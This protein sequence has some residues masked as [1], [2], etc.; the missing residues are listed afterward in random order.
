MVALFLIGHANRTHG[1]YPSWALWTIYVVSGITLVFT[2]VVIPV[3]NRRRTRF[4]LR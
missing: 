3:L 1:K 2:L 4:P